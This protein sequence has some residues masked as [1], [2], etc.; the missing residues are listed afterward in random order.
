MAETPEDLPLS[1]LLHR[2]TQQI[3]WRVLA[4]PLPTDGAAMVTHEGI[5]EL[6]GLGGVKAYRLS[7]GE[8]VFALEDVIRLLR[9]GEK[10]ERDE[11]K[12]G[13]EES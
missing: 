8:A 7:S 2:A 4:V 13:E 6:P 5:L 9:L 10:T 11:R 12:P 3:R 1:E